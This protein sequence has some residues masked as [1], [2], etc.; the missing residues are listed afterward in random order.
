[1]IVRNETIPVVIPNNHIF[2]L[3]I[4]SA[5]KKNLVNHQAP[6][7]SWAT[8]AYLDPKRAVQALKGINV[9]V[10]LTS[11]SLLVILLS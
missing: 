7:A 6:L 2:C 10:A 1:M 4:F 8:R 9:Q 11:C 3:Q 5:W